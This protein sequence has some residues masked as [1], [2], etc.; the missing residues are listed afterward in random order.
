METLFLILLP[1]EAFVKETAYAAYVGTS[2]DCDPG[3]SD[4]LVP[5]TTGPDENGYYATQKS[6]VKYHVKNNPGASFNVTC[7]PSADASA[8]GMPGGSASVSYKVEAWAV[9]IAVGGTTADPNDQDRRKILPGQKVTGVVVY[10][11]DA[12]L[13]PALN[14][15]S[16]PPKHDTTWTISGCSPFLDY[17][18]ASGNASGTLTPYTS[19]QGATGWAFWAKPG[20]G[21]VACTHKMK[22]TEGPQTVFEVDL[23]KTVPVVDL[24]EVIASG[25]AISV[26][27]KCFVDATHRWLQFSKM[28]FQGALRTPEMFWVGQDKGSWVYAQLVLST[29]R[30]YWVNGTKA[31]LPPAFS[32]PPRLDNSF[33]YPETSST[34]AS[35]TPQEA[36]D[37]PGFGIDKNLQGLQTL[38]MKDAF[39]MYWMYLP[40]NVSGS[41]V[42]Y[43]PIA[44]CDWR[45]G[46]SASSALWIPDGEIDL[47][48]NP[49]NIVTSVV[50]A[51]ELWIKPHPEWTQI[52]VNQ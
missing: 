48:G 36:F 4:N 29:D 50:E 42:R 7:T 34:V 38:Y 6:A 46:L 12:P 1:P 30:H 3:F 16:D 8:P 9:N 10:G 31:V 45:V 23:E 27:A 47:G 5:N 52:V 26:G 14:E 37:A 41:E 49:P 20:T 44:S 35:G 21:K 2:G 40:P 24:H 51:V 28:W 18:V 13:T 43:V 25:E 32:T 39:R 19:Q 17:V 11:D 22:L 33:P 15:T